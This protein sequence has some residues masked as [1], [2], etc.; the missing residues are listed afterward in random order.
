[1]SRASCRRPRLALHQVVLLQV[2]LQDGVFD[3]G[4]DKTDV[5]CVGGTGEVRVDDLVAVWIQVHKH[6][7]DKLSPCLGIPLGTWGGEDMRGFFSLH[8]V[9]LYILFIKI[10]LKRFYSL[11]G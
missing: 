11:A 1:M 2:E 10:L 4:E 3:G 8:T 5:L 9:F 7:E 6:L